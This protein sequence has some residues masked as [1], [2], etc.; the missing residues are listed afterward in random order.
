MARTWISPV[1]WPK[2]LRSNN[3][4]AAVKTFA[5][6]LPWDGM[7]SAEAIESTLREK[8]GA[9]CRKIL[10]WAIVRIDRSGDNEKTLRCEGAYLTF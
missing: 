1:T 5:I 4:T 7:P 3:V 8:L 6:A 2:A 10:R 9:S